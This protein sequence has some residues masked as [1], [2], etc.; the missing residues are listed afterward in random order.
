[1]RPI[2]LIMQ[3]FTSFAER[4]EIDFSN[5]DLFAITGPTGSGK[6]SVLD[7]MTWA[8]YGRTRRVSK[9]AELISHS[10]DRV[11]V[12]LEFLAGMH[13]YRITRVAKRSG[14]ARPVLEKWQDGGW[15]PEE[16][17]G[18][19]ETEEAIRKIVGLDFEAFTTAVILPQGEFDRFLR[20]D[21]KDRREIL[22]SLLRLEVYDR[23][24]D[25]AHRRREEKA[26]NETFLKGKIE[27]EYADATEEYVNQREAE[28][29][30]REKELEETASLLDEA[31]KLG[32]LAG[33]IEDQRTRLAEKETERSKAEIEYLEASEQ[34]QEKTAEANR[35][36]QED[37]GV[38]NEH[39]KLAIDERRASELSVL[40]AEADQLDRLFTRQNELRQDLQHGQAELDVRKTELEKVRAFAGAAEAVWREAEKKHEQSQEILDQLRATGSTDLLKRLADDLSGVAEKQRQADQI[41][42]SIRDA[43]SQ[44]QE[45]RAK[46]AELTPRREAAEANLEKAKQELAELTRHAVHHDLRAGLKK[47]EPCPVCEQVVTVLPKITEAAELKTAQNRVKTC[48]EELRRLE[49]E[50]VR[51]QTELARLPEKLA[52]LEKQHSQASAEIAGIR[53]RVH[54][55]TGVLD[56]NACAEVLNS[57]I[58][59]I[60]A[61]EQQVM[62]AQEKA[63]KDAQV[64][65]D[66]K[67]EVARLDRDVA[68]LAASIEAWNKEL[69]GVA[70]E[71]QRIQPGVERAGGRAQILNDLQAIE[72]DR[73]RKAE[74]AERERQL[75]VA[76]DEAE[77]KKS[78]A[79][80]KAAVLG[81]RVR[82]LTGEIGKIGQSL[83]S[84]EQQWAAAISGRD[85]PDGES[86]TERAAGWRKQLQQAY[87]ALQQICSQLRTDIEATKK[88][89]E[90]LSELQAQLESLRQERELYDQ[91]HSSLRAD[92]FIDHLLSRAYDDLCTRG[93]EHL[94]RLSSERY[95][96]V[97][98]K[99]TFNVRDA[100]N[101]DA[102]RPAATLSGGESFFASLALALALSESVVSFSADGSRGAPLEALF[103]DEGVSTLDQDESLPAVVD[104]LMGLQAGER[105]IGVI[106]HME[107][108]AAR[109]PARIEIVKNHGRSTVR[110]EDSAPEMPAVAR[111]T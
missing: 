99:N 55:V 54:A 86:E 31:H 46:V 72:A 14:T 74:L 7:A 51:A 95:C 1:M 16:A 89:I 34:E 11:A 85:L 75:R 78:E 42:S 103:L 66:A 97:A 24:R 100:W 81:E 65:Q 104:A 83:E 20:G 41:S 110:V 61:A 36:R 38:A 44:R 111:F 59:K 25:L 56:D 88:K 2:K 108:F 40:R 107:N 64:H 94:L 105:M 3:G 39:D 82:S 91:I 28:L 48:E 27:N 80:Q 50:A 23:M 18:V 73:K 12:H 106:S 32:Q 26:A 5:L 87:N 10:A 52:D 33:Q 9:A 15:S 45:L 4:V 96:F 63:K 35:L 17:S 68:A 53:E 29:Q 92:R 57:R 21:H 62:Q 79:Q 6:T 58:E 60:R 109:L 37:E 90:H 22:K 67:D 93:S 102:E 76:I 13:R 43:H 98:G 77:R 69:G 8:L 30:Q 47:G 84:L 101:G 19:R 70:A 49:T 71:I